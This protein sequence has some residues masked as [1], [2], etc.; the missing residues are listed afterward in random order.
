MSTTQRV[1][2]ARNLRKAAATAAA[3][4]ASTATAGVLQGPAGKTRSALER[5]YPGGSE[6]CGDNADEPDVR[7]PA[8]S[9]QSKAS[10]AAAW[11]CRGVG[12]SPLR[13]TTSSP[14]AK[15]A[16]H[17]LQGGCV[18]EGG[19]HVKAAPR[20]GLF[21]DTDGQGDAMAAGA[22]HAQ[23]RGGWDTAGEGGQ[24]QEAEEGAGSNC[25]SEGEEDDAVE[26]ANA[27]TA[28]ARSILEAA[29]VCEPRPGTRHADA[30]AR[31]GDRVDAAGRA[32]G[33][34]AARGLA[35][36]G[37]VAGCRPEIEEDDDVV[38]RCTP[39][40]A[41]T[42]GAKTCGGTS[43]CPRKHVDNPI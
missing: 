26:T 22:A 39:Q 23:R 17:G 3:A 41:R 11:R 16:G 35:A 42:S 30:A 34:P 29:S 31:G 24:G 32:V 25:A 20:R 38:L 13:D 27:A 28:I 9:D 12:A 37:A 4:R 40:A 36:G 21:R 33:A 18:A 43:V 7:S 10:P 14:A 2:T 19:K 8:R 6:D 1:S 15:E 5:P